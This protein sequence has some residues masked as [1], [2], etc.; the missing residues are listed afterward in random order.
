[1][2]AACEVID[3]CRRLGGE[4][5]S[6][7]PW[8]GC[9]RDR[10]LCR[11]RAIHLVHP[12]PG[13]LGVNQVTELVHE[14]MQLPYVWPATPDAAGARTAGAGSRAAPMAGR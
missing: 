14:V 11:R 7:E 3:I 2:E 1:V 5:G 10:G 13:T 12:R 8:G 6:I 9:D 4:R